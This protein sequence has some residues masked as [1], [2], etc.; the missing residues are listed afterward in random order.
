MHAQPQSYVSND[1]QAHD[2]GD[3]SDGGV[4]VPPSY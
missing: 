4:S 2:D 3:N 1:A